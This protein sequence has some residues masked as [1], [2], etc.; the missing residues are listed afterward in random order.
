MK[1]AV[2]G[3]RGRMGQMLCQAVQNAGLELVG[4]SEVKGSDCIGQNLGTG[5]IVDN[6]HDLF[7]K[8]DAVLDFTS[9]R[10][11]VEN[12]LVAAETGRI[13]IVGTTGLTEEQ[14]DILKQASQK[15][16]IVYASN[17]SVGVNLLLALVEKA[18][19][20]L[21]A[22]DAEI[23]EMHHRH[24]KDAPSGTAISLGQAVAKGRQVSLTE[25]SCYDRQGER[26]DGD[27]GFAVLRGGD[28]AGDHTVIF[29]GN[30]E[31]VELTHKAS[32]RTVFAEG[33]VKA[34][35]WAKMQKAGLY[36]MRDVLGF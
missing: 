4:G 34:A 6:A 1:I 14:N 9:A 10:N 8:A 23:V 32:S 26:K 21:N 12:A 30:G 15:A 22:Y 5:K 11:S 24:K 2:A 19:S 17:M 27:I 36:S 3:C 25:K 33:A 35:L 7:E 18:A 16:R 29:A 31:R 20:V 13:L 28:V